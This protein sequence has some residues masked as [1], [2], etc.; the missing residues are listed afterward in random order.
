MDIETQPER[1]AQIRPETEI[2][3]ILQAQQ[4]NAVLMAISKQPYE[5]AAPL[6]NAI[7]SQCI[8]K[9]GVT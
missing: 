7:Q 1:P 9:A 4:W 6:M 3:V 5:L 8:A 2:E